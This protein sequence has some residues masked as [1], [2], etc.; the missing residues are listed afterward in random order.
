M[1]EIA[2]SIH[3]SKIIHY[4]KNE[5]GLSMLDRILLRKLSKYKILIKEETYAGPWQRTAQYFNLET[6]THCWSH[7]LHVNEGHKGTCFVE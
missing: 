6:Q 7:Y 5:S 2:K 4:I 1:D 3:F